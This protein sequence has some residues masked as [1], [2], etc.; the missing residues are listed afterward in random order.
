MGSTAALEAARRGECD[1]AGIHLL[2]PA[3]GQYNRPW[4]TPE[5]VLIPG[6][7]RIQGVLFRPDDCRFAGRDA[8]A[9]IAAVKGD[10]TCLLVNR[11]PGSGTRILIDGLLAGV[12]PAGYT[13]Q[14]RSHNAVAAA[15][16]Q[17]RADWGVAIRS[18]AEQA[19]LGFLPLTEEHY[20]FVVP[21]ARRER[22]AVQAFQQLLARPEVRQRLRELGCLVAD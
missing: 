20:D 11:N 19:G 6:Y 13:F 21:R 22:P 7:G 14:P 17:G 16:A 4:L 10:P 9:A 3:T 15:V 8:R 12:Q 2:D 5:L 18:V 1:L